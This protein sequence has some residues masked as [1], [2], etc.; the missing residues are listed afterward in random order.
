MG[1]NIR[2]VFYLMEMTFFGQTSDVVQILLRTVLLLKKSAYS[3]S[4]FSGIFKYFRQKLT[5]KISWW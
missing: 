2:K 5:K 3:S 4:K 1:K